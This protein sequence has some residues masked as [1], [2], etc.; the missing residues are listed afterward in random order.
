MEGISQGFATVC[1]GCCTNHFAI[2]SC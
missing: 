1:H 2:K